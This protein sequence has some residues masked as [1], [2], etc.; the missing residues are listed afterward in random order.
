MPITHITFLIACLAIAGIPPFAGFFSKEEILQAAFQ[1]NMPIFI[2]AIATAA[3][4]AFYMFR[5]YFNIF[6][7]KD[8]H[9]HHSPE[10]DNHEETHHDH[11]EGPFTMML[12]LML[13]ALL[14]IGA[15]FVPFSHLVTS[16][17]AA[18]ATEFHIS[19]SIAPVLL[20]S[21]GILLAFRF[22]KSENAAPQ[23]MADGMSSLYRGAY[24]KFYIDEI[25]LFI[26]KKIIFNLIGKSAAWFDRNIVDGTMNLLASITGKIS[27]LI[28]RM[29][30]GKTQSYAAYFFAGVL[31]FVLVF[32]YLWT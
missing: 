28:K 3:I 9:P 29:Q 21:C 20:A 8:F 23:K 14:S 4:T 19:F 16:D 12:P 1:H 27:F 6:W 2:I 5:L 22:Y 18:L 10:N 11:G 26:T 15:G 13:L 25:Y 7:S 31:G 30:S 32:V 24:H 17:G